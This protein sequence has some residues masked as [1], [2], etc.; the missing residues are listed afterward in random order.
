MKYTQITKV[1][2][3]IIFSTKGVNS[4]TPNRKYAKDNKSVQSKE[5]DDEEKPY[6]VI[7]QTPCCVKFFAIAIWIYGSSRT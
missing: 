7:P 6:L 1:V 3:N 4:F 5:D 2:P